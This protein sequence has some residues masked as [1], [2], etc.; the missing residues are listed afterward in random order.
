M[1]ADHPR[2]D[3]GFADYWFA[4][5]SKKLGV[6]LWEKKCSGGVSYPPVAPGG[7]SPRVLPQNG[8]SQAD[9]VLCPSVQSWWTF[10]VGDVVALA[11]VDVAW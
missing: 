5:G 1:L 9:G 8:P 7:R 11:Y 3:R 10:G 4:T 2:E 6:T